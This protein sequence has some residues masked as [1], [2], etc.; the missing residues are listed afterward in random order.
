M[1]AAGSLTQANSTIQVNAPLT[2]TP[3]AGTLINGVVTLAYN[4]GTPITFTASG[5]LGGYT[6]FDPSDAP[7]VGCSPTGNFPPG[8]TFPPNSTATTANLAGTPTTAN[9]NVTPNYTFEICVEDTFNAATNS[10]AATNGNYVTVVVEPVGVAVG[11]TGDT[12]EVFHTAPFGGNV[13]GNASTPPLDLDTLVGAGTHNPHSI[14]FTPNVTEAWVTLEG[15]NQIAIISTIDGSLVTT[16]DLTA[17]TFAGAANQCRGPRGIVHGFGGASNNRTYVACSTDDRIAVI[18]TTTRA[19][20]AGPATS[21]GA[22]TDLAI[23]PSGASVYATLGTTR[24]VDVLDTTANTISTVA[25]VANTGGDTNAGI[26][27]APDGSRAFLGDDTNDDVIMLTI[28]GHVITRF[29]LTGGD[30]PRA[31]AFDPTGSRVYITL[32][33]PNQHDVRDGTT[34]ARV[35]GGPFNVHSFAI[36]SISRDGAGTVTVTTTIEHGLTS[37]QTVTISGNAQGSFNITTGAIT[38]TGVNTFTFAQAGAALS[39]AGGTGVP[40]GTNPFG[41][42]I[43]PSDGQVRVFTVLTG[44]GQVV[45]HDE[46]ATPARTAPNTGGLI[47]PNPFTLG[48]GSGPTRVFSIPR[49]R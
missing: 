17:G 18:N 15:S 27:I 39:G 48:A 26:A 37:G 43:P 10:G 9:D 49:P 44:L 30:N 42:T 23:T 36:T 32:D 12:L 29:A 22:V 25:N 41:I 16:I 1:S 5:G 20:V 24:D 13:I 6:F 31:V 35:A 46:S 47:G 40:G 28:P 33:G 34:G 14:A 8:L 11:T 3:A 21:G 19:R 45:V 4:N 2:L 38:V 7:G